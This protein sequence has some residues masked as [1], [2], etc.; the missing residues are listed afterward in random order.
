M[1]TLNGHE[2]S[3]PQP[4]EAHSSQRSEKLCDPDKH[5]YQIVQRGE[6]ADVYQCL[7][8]DHTITIV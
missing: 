4:A 2:S 5:D 8:C 3:P 6:V 1:G 7:K